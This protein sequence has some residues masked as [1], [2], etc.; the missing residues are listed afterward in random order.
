MGAITVE[1]FIERA[2]RLDEQEQEGRVPSHRLGLYVEK[3]CRWGTF[4][5][6]DGY[7]TTWVYGDGHS[8]SSPPTS[9]ASVIYKWCESTQKWI[10]RLGCIVWSKLYSAREPCTNG[11]PCGVGLESVRQLLNG[12]ASGTYSGMHVQAWV[13]ISPPGF[14]QLDGGPPGGSH[15]SVGPTIPSPHTSAHMHSHSALQLTTAAGLHMEIHAG[16]NSFGSHS[17]VGSTTSLPHTD[18]QDGL[19]GG[20]DCTTHPFPMAH[21]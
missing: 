15:S 11:V 8:M 2:T 14:G 17:S 5:L 13:H 1:N 16:K 21:K 18:P 7:R 19:S 9:T 4:D 10:C 6:H 3:W 12:L 20:A